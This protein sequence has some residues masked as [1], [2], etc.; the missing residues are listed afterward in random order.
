MTYSFKQPL[1]MILFVVFLAGCTSPTPVVITTPS[2]APVKGAPGIG[3]S[4][5]PNMGN[6]GYDVE[7]YVIALDVDPTTNSINGSV[8]IQATATKFL[9]SFN[10]DFH[11]LTVDSVTV[12]D[13]TVK[14]S[15]I[16]DELTITPSKPL[17]INKPFT[18]V[19]E[20]HGSPEL[21]ISQAAPFP[22]GWSYA[23]AGSINIW[24]EPDAAFSWFPNNNHPR[25]KAT[26]RFEITVLNP[27]IVAATGT[28]KETK[29]NG[30]KTT[31]IWEM[32]QPM[33]TYLASIN[34]D[35]Y[36]LVT[37]T[38]PNGLIIR[39]YFPVDLG[40]AYRIDFDIIPEAIDFFDDLFGPYPFEEYGVVVAAEGGLCEE[41]DLALEA[42][43][44]SIHC[45][46]ATMTS[47]WVIVHELAHQWFGDSVSLENW[48]DVWL[49][50]GFATYAE[51]LWKTKND[52]DGIAKTAKRQEQL[53]FDSEYPVVS[54]SPKNLYTNESYIGG[55]LV[56]QALR[57]EVGDEV[58]F[59]ILQTYA[60]KY[61]YGV[62]GTDDF[63]A[64][65]NEVSGRDLKS[66]FDKWLFSTTLPQLPE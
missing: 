26:Y 59:K 60:E 55:A 38:G 13:A 52:P 46:S 1:C 36:D 64:V 65:A 3:D 14:S 27:W 20:Y 17:E 25:D 62:A 66:F 49:K 24:G 16:E 33:T 22:M 4:Y 30:N 11:V 43:S 7:H 57:L 44:M 40:K 51:W 10:L 56:L 37:Q 2:P 42:Q 61:R 54:P 8:T 5:Y 34:I 32:N 58:F 31:F 28:L 23:E 35:R 48:Q 50:E 15:R 39:N 53:F 6:G 41:V 18:V 63:I 19:V 12:N 47:D 9:A 29:E 45:P 21:F